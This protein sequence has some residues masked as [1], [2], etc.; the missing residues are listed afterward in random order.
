MINQIQINIDNPAGAYYNNMRSDIEA[1][2]R[3]SARE[4][5]DPAGIINDPDVLRYIITDYFMRRY[6]HTGRQAIR[7]EYYKQYMGDIAEAIDQTKSIL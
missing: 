7:D 5:G 4:A 2:I 1:D 6:G 3:Q